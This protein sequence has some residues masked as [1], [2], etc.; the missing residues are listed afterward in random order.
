MPNTLTR[1]YTDMTCY[2]LKTVIQEVEQR[3]SFA[4][5][6]LEDTIFHPQGGGQPADQGSIE[7]DRAV[8][9]VTHVK[10]RDDGSIEHIG[11]PIEGTFAVG[12]QVTCLVDT[13]ARVLH[14]RLHSAGHLLD[15]A[16]D[17]LGIDWQPSKGYH[18]MD[19]P[20][21]EYQTHTVPAPDLAQKIKEQAALL[22]A[23]NI[24]TAIELQDARRIVHLAGKAVP[25]GGTHVQATGEIGEILIRNIKRKPGVIRISYSISP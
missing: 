16:L 18:F 2:E 10:K 5:V 23:Q 8:M 20:Y 14:S 13:A 17:Q 6:I 22:I 15:V 21:V 24:P 4:V 3:D 12:D 11:T 7:S 19:G 9:Q 1:Y 25:C